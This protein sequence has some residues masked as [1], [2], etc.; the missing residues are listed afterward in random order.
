[1]G[2]LFSHKI[3]SK[4]TVSVLFYFFLMLVIELAYNLQG[5]YIKNTNTKTF[6]EERIKRWHITKYSQHDFRYKYISWSTICR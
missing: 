1:M 5:L 2:W 4:N 6:T 3:K